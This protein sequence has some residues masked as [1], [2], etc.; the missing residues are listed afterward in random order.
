MTDTNA[1]T[2][3]LAQ[4]TFLSGIGLFLLGG[5]VGLLFAYFQWKTVQH[6]IQIEKIKLYLFL[7]ALV[8]FL[9]FF[10]ALMWV[11]YPDKNIIKILIF[12]IGF[13]F[14]RIIAIKRVKKILRERK[15]V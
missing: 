4:I 5:A 3:F 1:L 11:A 12:F 2:Y 7:T 6:I 8:R 13:M 15:N 9:I 14:I 10:I